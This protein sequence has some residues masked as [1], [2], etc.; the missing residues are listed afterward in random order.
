LTLSSSQDTI[1]TGAPHFLRTSDCEAPE[2]MT[3][4]R[5]LRVDSGFLSFAETGRVIKIKQTIIMDFI[6]A[7]ILKEN[8]G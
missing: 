3:Y 2:V 5:H 8:T 6:S 7:Y 1:S 4:E